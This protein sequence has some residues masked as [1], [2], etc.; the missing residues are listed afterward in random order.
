MDFF[1]R[2]LWC[3]NAAPALGLIGN[4]A[5]YVTGLPD[6]SVFRLNY[7]GPDTIK[8][9]D[10]EMAVTTASITTVID[11]SD[12]RV[13]D[14]SLESLVALTIGS[15]IAMTIF[16]PVPPVGGLL[17]FI[18]PDSSQIE[19][20]KNQHSP[21]I[22]ADTGIT[23]FLEV[24]S[25][26][27]ARYERMKVVV[28]GGARVLGQTD[29]IDIGGRNH[30]VVKK[31]LSQYKIPIYHEDVGGNFSRSLSLKIGDGISTLKIIG[32]GEVK[33]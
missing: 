2:P 20:L 23:A 14:Q 17:N 26:M 10:E 28:A 30:D 6:G 8:K 27:G 21:Y 16:D 18:L 29:T 3:E 25:E 4:S 12:M 32:R 31:I 11:Y 7:D 19:S 22:F 15:G 1:L 5:G 24:L 33:I 9:D 13:S